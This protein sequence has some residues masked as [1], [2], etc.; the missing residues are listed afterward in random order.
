[1]N[2]IAIATNTF[3]PT[4]YEGSLKRIKDTDKVRGDLALT[5]LKTACALGYNVVV[6]DRSTSAFVTVLS[7][8]NGLRIIH[9]GEIKRSPA[10]RK[11]IELC[12]Q[13]SGVEVIVSTEPEK[14]SF[15][16]EC[17]SA[18]VKPVLEEEIDIVLPKR[19]PHLFIASYP[20]FQYESEL[21][22]NILFEEL[23]RSHGLF[24]SREKDLDM[25]FGP[26]VFRNSQKTVD[27]FMHKFI[28]EDANLAVSHEYFD[29]EQIAATLFFPIV[30]AQKKNLRIKT[31][32]VPFRYPILQK[33]NEE[34]MGIT[35]FLKKRRDQRIGTATS[36]MHLIGF[37][38]GY[39][40]SRIKN[41]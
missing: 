28:F 3:Y 9:E 27:C 13:L 41:Q 21:E 29:P 38:E 36:L 24:P 20:H 31:V 25:V 19:D 7:K 1:M 17:L 12:S 10:R 32:T 30:F 33:K 16:T 22:A 2:K 34:A 6:T 35:L 8:I 26:R 5:F 18:T 11:A 39:S 40:A 15:L 4:W 37:L 14:T 23:L